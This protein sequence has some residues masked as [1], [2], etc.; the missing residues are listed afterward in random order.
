MGIDFQKLP[1]GRADD[2]RVA[3]DRI[4]SKIIEAFAK[5]PGAAVPNIVTVSSDYAVK[6]NED[7]IH[8]DA[9]RGPVKIT[10]LPPSSA[11]RPLTIK[12]VNLQNGKSSVNTVTVASKDGSATIAGKS[13]IDLDNTGT[14]SVSFSSS[15]T[16]HWPATN[17]G[18]NPPAGGGAGIVYTGIPPIFVA[19]TQI[20]IKQGP[21]PTPTP[22]PT[23]P[24]VAPITFGDQ[25]IG[26][27]TGSETWIAETVVDFTGSPSSLVLYWWFQ[28]LSSVGSA[29]FNIRI[30]GSAYKA[31]DGVIAATW[32]E[33]S[34]T[35]V[36][37]T[38]STALAAPLTG[39]QRVTLT[40]KASASAGPRAQ[41]QGTNLK[42]Q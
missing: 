2:W 25:L 23:V 32:M 16:Q 42:F 4:Q 40:A 21:S 30:G 34:P 1:V 15:D 9:Q 29:V 17:S 28:A 35:M 19:G 33:T 10:M 18:G 22:T 37:H 41:I 11:N 7:V 8:V 6:G 24:W 36:A 14:G 13:S 20:G 31:L 39:P 12:Q 3:L 26:D 38:I 5:V 27:T